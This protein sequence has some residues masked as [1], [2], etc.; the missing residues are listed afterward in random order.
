MVARYDETRGFATL[1]QSRAAVRLAVAVAGSCAELGAALGLS[2]R[3]VQ[4]W[5]WAYPVPGKHAAAVHGYAL[6]AQQYA[7]RDAHKARMAAALVGSQCALGSVLGVSQSR[8][9]KWVRQGLL[10]HKRVHRAALNGV[11]VEHLPRYLRALNGS[12]S[13]DLVA[14]PPRGAN[15]CREAA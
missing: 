5:R 10:P 6:R 9:S 4:N 15:A 1:E 7:Q 8:V 13:I 11:L 3:T 14:A 12:G 2:P